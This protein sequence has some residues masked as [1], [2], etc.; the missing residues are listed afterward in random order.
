M[1]AGDLP[2][3]RAGRLALLV[4]GLGLGV[5][6]LAIIHGEPA[7][8]LAGDALAAAMVG[9]LAGWCLIVAGLGGLC[10]MG[11]GVFIMAKMVNFEI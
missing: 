11:I 3:K 7:Y 6:F 4:A 2:L 10:W 1:I 9:L 8:S 5:M